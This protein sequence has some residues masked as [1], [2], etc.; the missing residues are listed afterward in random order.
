ML[1]RGKGTETMS[2]EEEKRMAGS[3]EYCDSIDRKQ[4]GVRQ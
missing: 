4:E 1:E 3:R 2:V